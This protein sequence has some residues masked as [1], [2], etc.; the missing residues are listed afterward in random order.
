GSLIAGIAGGIPATVGLSQL[1]GGIAVI[2]SPLFVVIIGI[3]WFAGWAI[4]AVASL[5]VS[6]SAGIAY[7]IG[8]S[9][10]SKDR[11]PWIIVVAFLPILLLSVALPI[12]GVR[13]SG[14]GGGSF[15]AILAV[16]GFVPFDGEFIFG[17]ILFWTARITIWISIVLF[18][19][20]VSIGTPA[21][22]TRKFEKQS[23]KASA[24]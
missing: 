17:D 15:H 9:D 4:G 14:D 18:V 24:S 19:A 7:G 23:L 6:T 1:F 16:G 5:I 10:R 20:L 3:A 13:F 11:L 22:L 12:A 8:R 2:F 21:L